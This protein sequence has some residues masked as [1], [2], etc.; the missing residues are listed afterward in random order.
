MQATTSEP[1]YVRSREVVAA[2]ADG[3]AILLNTKRWV[4]LGFDG[5][6]TT[7]WNLLDEPRTLGSLVE[8]LRTRFEVDE[9]TCAADT[10]SFLDDMI[11]Q[12]V[13]SMTPGP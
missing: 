13:V 5:V 2:E 3:N 11:E 10:K 6:G 8:V 7:I 4:Y 1:V 12:G 9:T